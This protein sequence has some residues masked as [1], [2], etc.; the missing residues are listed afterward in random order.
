MSFALKGYKF[1][2][3]DGHKQLAAWLAVVAQQTKA[4]TYHS[5]PNGLL[6]R[7]LIG[8]AVAAG[9]RKGWPDL[10]I[11]LN[12]GRTMFI[13]LKLKNNDLSENQK[14]IHKEIRMM[15]FDVHVVRFVTPNQCVD[16]V[17]D[18]LNEEYGMRISI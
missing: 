14:M 9:M 3:Y 8:M 7:H 17:R 10:Q 2:E 1:S 6:S 5:S 18:L 16:K 15:G 13:E 4:L 11:H 12:D